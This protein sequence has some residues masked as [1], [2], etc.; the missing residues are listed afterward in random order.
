MTDLYSLVAKAERA[1]SESGYEKAAAILE[2]L[3]E[4]S[5]KDSSVVFVHSRMYIEC[6]RYTELLDLL[7]KYIEEKGENPVAYLFMGVAELF[8]DNIEEALEFF[9]KGLELSP[10]NVLLRDYSLLC[11][12]A[13][14]DT[15]VI[16]DFIFK[17]LHGNTYFE[18]F[19]Y[20]YL[21]LY[22][23]A[24]EI[25]TLRKKSIIPEVAESPVLQDTEAI[26]NAQES[27]S[28]SKTS[29][30]DHITAFLYFI[31][32]KHF[33]SWERFELSIKF[34]SRAA[35][36]S[37]G[38]NRLH[39]L[40]GEAL[41][42]TERYSEAYKELSISLEQDGEAPETLYYLGRI[43]QQNGEFEQAEDYFKKTLEKF[44]KFP[45]VYYALG[46]IALI[47]NDRSRALSCFYTAC[48]GDGGVLEEILKAA[49][50]LRTQSIKP[51]NTISSSE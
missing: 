24:S 20:L 33:L 48:S 6:A 51:A 50:K 21:Y 46:E 42:Y 18:A 27:P 23:N 2:S 32:G 16:E 34:L 3:P 43:Y 30:L 4:S 36:L 15:N 35:E 13:A 11:R 37:P 38:M 19:L 25:E 28:A 29:V 31:A 22:V 39:F 7:S 14:G 47:K 26:D 45:E 5:Q 10:E 41:I 40:L 9:E 12:F 17:Y 8:R 44:S 49:T 1:F